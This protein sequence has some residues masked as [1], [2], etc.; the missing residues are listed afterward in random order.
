MVLPG[1]EKIC[2][3]ETAFLAIRIEGDGLAQDPLRLLMCPLRVEEP[4]QPEP[5][6]EQRG[7]RLDHAASHPLRTGHI[8]RLNQ[9]RIQIVQEI[10]VFRM[11]IQ[12]PLQRGLRIAIAL[13]LAIERGQQDRHVGLGRKLRPQSLGF[14]HRVREFSLNSQHRNLESLRLRMLRIFRQHLVCR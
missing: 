9:D 5:V 14:G 4:G 10:H 1:T 13:L 12:R 11:S 6:I 8:F 3:Q 7:F 2:Q